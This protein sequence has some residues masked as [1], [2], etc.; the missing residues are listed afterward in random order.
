MNP[1]RV[2]GAMLIGLIPAAGVIF[3]LV[4][5]G[6]ITLRKGPD[7]KKKTPEKPPATSKE[8]RSRPPR[9]KA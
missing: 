5:F 3:G 1:D 4:M 7:D 9:G 2:V 6:V 8:P